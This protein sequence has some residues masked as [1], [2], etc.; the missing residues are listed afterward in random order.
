LEKKATECRFYP[1]P[2]RER[3]AERV[4]AAM[5]EATIAPVVIVESPLAAQGLKSL[6][7]R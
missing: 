2:P 3:L 5:A 1:V 4:A 6:L 7:S